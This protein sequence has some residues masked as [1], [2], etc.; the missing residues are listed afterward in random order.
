M[1]E[2][3][4]SYPA[5]PLRHWFG[6]RERF[7][8]SIPK[9]VTSTYLASALQIE[10]NSASTNVMP[11]LRAC[12]LIAEDGTP[13][14][15]AIKWRDDA[16]Y[17]EACENIR[18]SVY[19]QELLDLAPPESAKADEVK[20]WFARK[21]GVG[22][23]AAGKMASFYMMLCE[24]N[25]QGGAAKTGSEKASRPRAEKQGVPKAAKIVKSPAVAKHPPP[26]Q[27]HEH[28]PQT[29]RTSAPT[30]SLNLQIL[31]SPDATAEQIDKVFESMAKHLKEFT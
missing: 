13:Q 29:K 3:P 25:P 18:T 30:L 10:E 22:D 26:T 5:V 1:A 31:I 4:K 12:G 11:G 24:A 28:A 19:A 16:H 23:S 7:K 9:T 6:L 21:G 14:D 17:K 2:G 20:R 15:L 8:K 27:E